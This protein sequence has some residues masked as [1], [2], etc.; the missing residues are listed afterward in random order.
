MNACLVF[1][2]CNN[3]CEN[4]LLIAS[5]ESAW[6]C[7]CKCSVKSKLLPIREREKRGKLTFS[8]HW[9]LFF[10]SVKCLQNSQKKTRRF[11]FLKLISW[12]I[13]CAKI[14]WTWKL[15]RFYLSRPQL[16]P[17]LVSCPSWWHC[18]AAVAGMLSSCD[19]LPWHSPRVVCW[20]PQIL[21]N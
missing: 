6:F 1:K 3:P 10:F 17:D 5:K 16:D 11:L 2:M 14:S 21:L 9:R 8:L 20:G 7:T 13:W 19:D 4:W 12:M 15:L 18:G